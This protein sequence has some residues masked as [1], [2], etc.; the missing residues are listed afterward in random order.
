MFR[1]LRQRLGSGEG[2][3]RRGWPFYY[4]ALLRRHEFGGRD[5]GV[6]ALCLPTLKV[7]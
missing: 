3:R 7:A 2:R 6:R 4:T 5:V 1:Q